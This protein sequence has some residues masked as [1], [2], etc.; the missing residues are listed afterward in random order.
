MEKIP[1][2]RF[3]DVP[4]EQAKERWWIAKVKPRQEKQLAFDFLEFGIE[5]YLP[6]YEKLTIR[7]G[8]NKKRYFSISLCHSFFLH[9]NRL[10]VSGISF[11]QPLSVAEHIIQG[12]AIG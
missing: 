5:Y 10:K 1:P 12:F 6:L 2:S 4:I 3:P 11:G 7:P 8:T 9:I